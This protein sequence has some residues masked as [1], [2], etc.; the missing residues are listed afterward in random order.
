MESVGVKRKEG[1]ASRHPPA[2]FLV[3]ESLREGEVVLPGGRQLLASVIC[4]CRLAAVVAVRIIFIV[5]L[6][7]N[8]LWRKLSW[9]VKVVAF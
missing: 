5:V 7:V 6:I 3:L 4:V 1:A 8:G 2:A 9:I